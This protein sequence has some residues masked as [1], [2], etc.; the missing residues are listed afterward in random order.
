[1]YSWLCFFCDCFSCNFSW[2]SLRIFYRSFPC[3]LLQQFL[4]KI[5]NRLIL[6]LVYDSLKKS[7]GIPPRIPPGIFSC[8][9]K[10]FIMK[11][12]QG[13]LPMFEQVLFSLFSNISERISFTR[14]SQNNST[15]IPRWVFRRIPWVIKRWILRLIPWGILWVI[16]RI[17]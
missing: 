5:L 12:L 1:M 15:G 6:K 3:A 8:I 7:T 17:C 13:L 11:F 4:K 14:N 9:T 2:D 10:E 16:L